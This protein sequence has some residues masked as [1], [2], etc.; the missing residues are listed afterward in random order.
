MVHLMDQNK[1]KN[2]Y[3]SPTL[4]PNKNRNLLPNI[5]DLKVGAT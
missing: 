5:I 2:S 3:F 1:T 4:S